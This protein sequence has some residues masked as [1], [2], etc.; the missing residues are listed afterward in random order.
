M[1]LRKKKASGSGVAFN[2]ID[3]TTR[4]FILISLHRGGGGGG[5]AKIVPVNGLLNIACHQ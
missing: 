1:S 4:S 5:F 3:D 2:G